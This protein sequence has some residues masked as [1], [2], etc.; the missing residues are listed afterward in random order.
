MKLPGWRFEHIG[1]EKD[2]LTIG[3]VD[4]WQTQW[5]DTQQAVQLPHPCHR[6]QT[7]GFAIREIG[8]LDS[9]V[10]F[11]VAELSAG[12]YGFYVPD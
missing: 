5:R 3:G 1:T 4:V 2:G 7:H 8:S 10:R 6:S 9:P 12:V 11:A